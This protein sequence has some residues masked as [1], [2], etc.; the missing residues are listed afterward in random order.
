MGEVL[1]DH[2]RLSRLPLREVVADAKYGTMANCLYLHQAGLRAF[3]PPR[4]QKAGPRGIWR[5]EHLRYLEEEDV[6]LCP[7]E[8][9]MKPFTRRPSTRRISFRVER[10]ACNAC[11]LRGQCMP[12]G[13]E[14]TIGCFFDQE[15][16][17]VALDRVASINLGETKKL[18]SGMDAIWLWRTGKLEE[19]A[20]Y[21]QG[22]VELTKRLFELWEA[23]GILYVSD[24][25]FVV[26]PG[27]FNLLD[28]EDD[29]E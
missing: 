26:W 9:R 15:L 19:L 12:S 28:R 8:M 24:T 10:G 11:R 7:A 18:E 21:C 4:Q 17:E 29:D 13:R 16:V 1:W 25:E 5:R 22:D 23:Q 6:F 3:I 14:R 20:A 2:T 27:I